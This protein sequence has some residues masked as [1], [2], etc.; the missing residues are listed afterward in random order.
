M[1]RSKFIGNTLP[2]NQA[3]SRCS[4]A[5]VVDS[6]SKCRSASP[7]GKLSLS[8]EATSSR[9]AVSGGVLAWPIE[10]GLAVSASINAQP[11]DASSSVPVSASRNVRAKACQVKAIRS[12]QKPPIIARDKAEFL[13]RVLSVLENEVVPKTMEGVRAGNKLFGAAVLN[14]SD[15]S[16]VIAGT[17]TETSNPLFHAEVTAIHQFYDL[18]DDQRPSPKDTIFIATH[19]PCP[20]CLSRI[21]WGGWDNFF[22]LCTYEDSRDAYGIPHDIVMLD[23]I[24]RCPDG[25]YSEKNKFWSS[26]SLR[27][28]IAGTPPEQQ[29]GFN[30]RV[31]ALKKTY[32]EMSEIYQKAKSAG[33][34][35]DV[36]LK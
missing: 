15:L 10:N 23:E 30:K 13:D 20:L 33:T 26:W 14:K 17:N 35:A 4:L 7:P 2:R 34:G 8:S 11:S 31:D 32:A 21:T 28:L 29:A 5:T 27:D 3:N 25:S 16:T 1:E 19:E 12:R 22:Y 36:P 9:I 24:V 18:P 6:Q